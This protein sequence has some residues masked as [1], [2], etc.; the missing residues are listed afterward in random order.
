MASPTILDTIP[1]NN[2]AHLVT[3]GTSLSFTYTVP[4]GGSNK[5]LVAMVTVSAGAF[6]TN[7]T[8]LTQNGVSFI[9]NFVEDD[10]ANLAGQLVYYLAAPASGTFQMNWTGNNNL[11]VTVFTI[12]DCVQTSP[13]DAHGT[14]SNSSTTITTTVSSNVGNDLL[15]A[16]AVHGFVTDTVSSYGA[17]Q[18]GVADGTN[19]SSN[20][21]ESVSWKAGAASPGSES[22]TTTFSNSRA[23]DQMVAYF[24]YQ[25]PAGG[26]VTVPPNLSLLGV[27]N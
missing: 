9:S 6:N 4:A 10:G 24:L 8:T 5:M 18:A 25:A 17:G 7:V 27:G 16:N 21:V 19:A 23:Q 20:W 1:D 3:L 13:I 2:L 15:L 14:A 11:I 22:M 12:Q 26:T